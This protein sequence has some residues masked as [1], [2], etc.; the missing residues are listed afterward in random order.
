MGR[1]VVRDLVET[2]LPD[3]DVV[4]ADYDG[5]AAKKLARSYGRRNVDGL[6]VDVTSRAPRAP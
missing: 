6:K 4:V 2:A 1:I 5:T 3:I